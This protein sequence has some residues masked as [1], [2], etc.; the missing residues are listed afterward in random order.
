MSRYSDALDCYNLSCGLDSKSYDLYWKRAACYLRLNRVDEA[1]RD[2]N[3]C[4]RMSPNRD[5]SIMLLAEVQAYQKSRGQLAAAPKIA[6]TGGRAKESKVEGDSV[7]DDEVVDDTEEFSGDESD[8][9]D[10][11]EGG[12]EDD[13]SEVEAVEEDPASAA[14]P[15]K[16]FKHIFANGPEKALA[17]FVCYDESTM[18]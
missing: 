14:M 3:E 6:P 8:N 18:Y 7:E 5:S 9:C 2:A 12:S 11:D 4:I 13:A 15:I 17:R 16:V 10:E 1:L